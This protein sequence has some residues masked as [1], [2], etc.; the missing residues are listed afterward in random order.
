MKK[1]LILVALV[2]AGAA[3]AQ[4]PVTDVANLVNNQL[5]QLENMAKWVESI[6]QLKTQIDQL[7]REISIQ[8]DIREW[9]GNPAEAG[10]KLVLDTLDE[11]DLLKPYGRTRAAIRAVTESL[12][13]LRNTS[14]GTY[15]AIL[16]ADLDGHEIA[17]DPLTF[18]RYAILD[19][20][21]S[22]AEQVADETKAREA[23]LQ[24]EIAATLLTLKS[25]T[26][27]AEVQKEAAKLTALNG[28]L[29][30][31][32]AARRREIDSVTLQ[33]IANDNRLEEERMAAAELAAKDD[34]LANQRVTAYLG[35]LKTRA[36][37]SP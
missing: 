34:Y 27:D 9:S 7:N 1:F 26:T 11:S 37:A 35:S 13:S 12:S 5:S 33:K 10:K 28:Q 24:Y 15:R 14:E 18:R 23:E 16:S 8:D 6:A 31:V 29:S 3:R 20:S 25:A 36:H 17:R 21:Q 22:N 4:I 32:E 19:A 30:Q 2:F